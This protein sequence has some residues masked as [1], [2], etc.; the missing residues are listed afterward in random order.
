M[1]PDRAPSD[2]PVSQG[3]SRGAA[4]PLGGF[5]PSLS[6]QLL[7]PRQ[8]NTHP[9]L[10]PQFVYNPAFSFTFPSG[11]FLLP[12]NPSPSHE[13]VHQQ[14]VMGRGKAI[15]CSWAGTAKKK[16]KKEK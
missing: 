14:E 5:P 9:S 1:P 8:G 11:R 3:E 7:L 12:P 10:S 13:Q 4:H 6:F 15:Q 16:K 2:A